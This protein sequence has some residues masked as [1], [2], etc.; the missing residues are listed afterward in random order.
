MSFGLIWHIVAVEQHD[1]CYEQILPYERHVS[2][3]YLQLWWCV[4]VSI[5]SLSRLPLGKCKI[6]GLSSHGKAWVEES[7]LH[8]IQTASVRY[9]ASGRS[10]SLYAHI[11]DLYCSSCSWRLFPCYVQSSTTWCNTTFF[12]GNYEPQQPFSVE[13][14][15][16]LYLHLSKAYTS[17]VCTKFAVDPVVIH[18][19]MVN[20]LISKDSDPYNPM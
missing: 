14:I 9:Y 8:I 5:L 6:F 18:V 2:I 12:L 13:K 7:L 20:L 15:G 10:T 3:K 1:I 17:Q 19:T 16:Y 4:L 11:F